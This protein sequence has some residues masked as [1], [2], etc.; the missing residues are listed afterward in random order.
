M[1]NFQPFLSPLL[2]YELQLQEIP[3]VSYGCHRFC[4]KMISYAPE[5]G[6]HVD[7]HVSLNITENKLVT[8][9]EKRHI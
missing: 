7:V 2:V 5:R 6:Y 9:I 8:L 3:P 1:G 4:E